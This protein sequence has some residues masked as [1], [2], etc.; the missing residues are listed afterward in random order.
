MISI[1]TKKKLISRL[2][3]QNRKMDICVHG[4]SMNPLLKDGDKI[5]IF[6]ADEVKPGNIVL[7]A[8]KNGLGILIHRVIAEYEG[9]YI[10]KGDNLKTLDY[11]IRRDDIMG[12]YYPSRKCLNLLFKLRSLSFRKKALSLLRIYKCAETGGRS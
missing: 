7:W 2:L 5:T 4:N 8:R 1:K 11:P 6:I 9:V 3:Q 10:T 12:I